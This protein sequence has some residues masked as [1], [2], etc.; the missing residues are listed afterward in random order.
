MKNLFKIIGIALLTALYCSTIS[1]DG[2]V[3]QNFDF[4]NKSDLG[5]EKKDTTASIKLL[6][7]IYQA[8]SLAE[9]FINTPPLAFKNQFNQFFSIER[10][11]E[12]FFANAFTQYMTTARNFLISNLK[13]KIIF[14][15]HYFW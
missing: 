4:I 3:S 11:R 10:V 14:P 15:F 2:S 9:P 7:N 8:E 12:Q 5:K 13:T 6:C 1:L